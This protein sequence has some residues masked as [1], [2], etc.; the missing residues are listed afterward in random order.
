MII[1]MILIIIIIIIIIIIMILIIIIIPGTSFE[2]LKQY[3]LII[4]CEYGDSILALHSMVLWGGRGG[5]VGG[6]GG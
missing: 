4:F 3:P 6:V 1:I 2:R 5:G